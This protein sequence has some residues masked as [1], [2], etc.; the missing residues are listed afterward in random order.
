MN[1]DENRIYKHFSNNNGKNNNQI[2]FLQNKKDKEEIKKTEES[3]NSLNE[4]IDSNNH[5]FSGESNINQKSKS[6]NQISNLSLKKDIIFNIMKERKNKRINKKHDGNSKD[7]IRQTITRHFIKFFFGFVNCYI[8][9][10]LEKEKI[11]LRK[12]IKFTI[13][14][15]DKEKIKLKDILRLTIE[16]FLSFDPNKNNNNELN[17]YRM[18]AYMNKEQLNI[19]KTNSNCS[20]DNFLKKRVIDLFKDIYI[21]KRKDIDLSN[22]EIEEELPKNIKIFETLKENN[23]YNIKKIKIMKSIIEALIINPIR[24]KV[25]FKT[26]KTE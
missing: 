5:I 17:D 25:H 10:K 19:I 4:N 14:Y 12:E 9:K 18:N 13:Y 24:K 20:L 11:Q 8:H 15:K 3:T 16:K 1:I 21:K 26:K 6:K 23:K 22:Y 7:N 2:I